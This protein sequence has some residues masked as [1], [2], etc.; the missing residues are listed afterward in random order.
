MLSLTAI[1]LMITPVV[2]GR[3]RSYLPSVFASHS[4]TGVFQCHSVPLRAHDDESAKTMKV[5]RHMEGKILLFLMHI[6]LSIR[7]S[8]GKAI[9]Q[10]RLRELEPTGPVS[11]DLFENFFTLFH[12]HSVDRF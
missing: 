11:H 12:F 4:Q 5:D 9:C 6:G 10:Q 3:A 7:P 8:L 2:A 1:R